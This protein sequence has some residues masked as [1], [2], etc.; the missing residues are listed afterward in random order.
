MVIKSLVNISS[1]AW[2]LDILAYL[3][4]G[5]SGRIAALQE[6]TGAGRTALSQSIK[7]LEAL[8][9]IE[10]NPGHGHPLRPEFRLTREGKQMAPIAD[11]V[12]SEISAPPSRALLRKHWSLPVLAL[13]YEPQYFSSLRAALPPITDRALSL[14]LQ[15]LESQSWLKREVTAS[16][17]P[18]PLYQSIGEGARIS[19]I[20]RGI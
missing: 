3:H 7:H 4:R 11:R 8:G 2:S 12:L 6:A 18:R 16:R 20:L 13:T 1:R 17:P 19:G 10:R 5:V 15:G 9:M 14:T